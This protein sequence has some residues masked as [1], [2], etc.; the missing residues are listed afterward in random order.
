M[1]K[2]EILRIRYPASSQL[3]VVLSC[4]TWLFAPTARPQSSGSKGPILP[5]GYAT[6]NDQFIP[7]TETKSLCITM[8]SPV[9][10]VSTE[11]TKPYSVIV[12][13]RILQTG[14]VVPLYASSGP[15]AARNAAMNAVRLWTYH[16]YRPKI[17][18]SPIEI[19]T[20]ITVP[21]VPGQPA[22]IIS[23]PK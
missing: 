13:A 2:G 17:Q 22:G 21:F 9:S 6:S 4:V 20:D 15:A 8:I 16:P 11:L 7:A 5:L 23:H 12:R 14:T 19:T 18:Q 1:R 10:P 3:I